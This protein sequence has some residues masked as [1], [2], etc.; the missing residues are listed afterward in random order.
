MGERLTV[1]RVN[2]VVMGKLT[3]NDFIKEPRKA[4]VAA[5]ELVNED[6]TTA[7]IGVSDV[8]SL[9]LFGADTISDSTAS[10]VAGLVIDF[11]ALLAS[12]R[13]IGII[14]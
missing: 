5:I 11:N 6:G 7:E 14:K 1:D 9:G 10:D 12:L 3:I 2:G 8:A 4:Q 13:T